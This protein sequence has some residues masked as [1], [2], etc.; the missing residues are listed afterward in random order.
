MSGYCDRCDEELW[1][2]DAQYVD[3]KGGTAT[4]CESY[5]SFIEENDRYSGRFIVECC[6]E[7]G[8][9]KQAYFK[10]YQKRGRK[11]GSQD[12]RKSDEKIDRY[13]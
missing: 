10:P 1:P 4:L 3:G 6:G 11:Q 2:D 13:G 7:C 5:A 9:V 12:Q 8:H